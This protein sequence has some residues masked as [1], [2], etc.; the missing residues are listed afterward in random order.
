MSSSWAVEVRVNRKRFASDLSIDPLL[1]YKEHMLRQEILA[2]LREHEADLRSRGVT[3]AA[4]FGS[5]ARGDNRQNSD[6]DI[7]I[8]I[9]RRP[10]MKRC[11]LSKWAG[12]HEPTFLSQALARFSR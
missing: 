1:C 10:R 9:A 5:R 4:L 6:T 3:H 8:E 11:M 7:M 2:T 12:R